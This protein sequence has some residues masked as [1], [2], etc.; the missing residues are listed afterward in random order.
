MAAATRTEA[1]QPLLSALDVYK[2]ARRHTAAYRGTPKGKVAVASMLFTRQ[3]QPTSLF[4]VVCALPEKGVEPDANGEIAVELIRGP[5]Q[6]RWPWFQG[7]QE[8]EYGPL[9]EYIVAAAAVSKEGPWE[10]KL[11][12]NPLSLP[13]V[14]DV[15]PLPKHILDDLERWPIRQIQPAPE[16]W[17]RAMRALHGG[18]EESS[19]DNKH[20]NR[21]EKPRSAKR[22][23]R[24]RHSSRSSTDSEQSTDSVPE[25]RRRSQKKSGLKRNKRRERRHKV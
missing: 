22:A 4:Q 11:A 12:E 1:T 18:R 6:P 13:E 3:E 7:D 21:R 20:I 8:V 5:T 15:P 25:T 17:V 24:A 23:K 14:E 9:K 16:A 10:E 2:L 19:D